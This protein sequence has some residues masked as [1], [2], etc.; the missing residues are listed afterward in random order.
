MEGSGK[1]QFL[2][3]TCFLFFDESNIYLKGFSSFD[4]VG[5]GKGAIF[6]QTFFSC[7]CILRLQTNLIF[8]LILTTFDHFLMGRGCQ[9]LL[10]IF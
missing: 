10:F 3:K 5:G 6:G 7:T 2:V 8:F 4:H 9:I 1:G